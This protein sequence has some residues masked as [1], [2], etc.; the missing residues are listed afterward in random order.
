MG[1]LGFYQDITRLI[2]VLGGPKIAVPVIVAGGYVV[3][4]VG[5]AS[6]RTVLRASKTFLASRRNAEPLE[7]WIYVVHTDCVEVG[8]LML[9]V[10]D[11]FRVGE[12]D[13]DAV[14]IDIIGDQNGPYFV[15]GDFLARVSNFMSEA[16]SEDN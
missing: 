5:E 8:G 7:G 10:G 11:Q 2:K 13:R 4:R 12:Q 6:V 9:R 14:L 16:Q 1:N 15:S 3:I